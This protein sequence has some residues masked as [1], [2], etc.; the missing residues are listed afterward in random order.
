MYADVFLSMPYYAEV[1]G[2]I[3]KN[4]NIGCNSTL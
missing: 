3:G 1:G 4:Q 2:C